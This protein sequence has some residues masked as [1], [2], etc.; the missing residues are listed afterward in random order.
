M[1][2]AI[3]YYGHTD[4][5]IHLKFGDCVKAYNFTKKF[6]K[7]HS[8]FAEKYKR[9]FENGARAGLNGF[10]SPFAVVAHAFKRNIPV[11]FYYNFTDKPATDYNE[12]IAYLVKENT[13]V[14]DT[15]AN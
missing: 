2:K 14:P 13:Y 9:Y 15:E 1:K 3:D 5:Y 11:H 10:N 6:I 12:I 4:N 7:E 8:D